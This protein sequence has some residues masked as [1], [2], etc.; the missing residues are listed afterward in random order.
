ML[1]KIR[2]FFIRSRDARSLL[3]LRARFGGVRRAHKTRVP[4]SL[5]LQTVGGKTRNYVWSARLG[6]Y[7]FAFSLLINCEI[8]DVKQFGTGEMLSGTVA[9]ISTLPP[10]SRRL[11]GTYVLTLGWERCSAVA[12]DGRVQNYAH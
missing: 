9:E 5:A 8:F 12:F 11:T 4:T 3:A 2:D 1:P 7:T 6:A 10:D